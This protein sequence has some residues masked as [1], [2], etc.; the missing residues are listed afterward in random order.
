MVFSSLNFLFI[1]LPVFLILYY[2]TPDRLKNLTLLGGSLVFYA[3]GTKDKP[4]YLLL[5]MISIAAN[6]VIGEKIGT[7]GAGGRRRGWLLFGLIYNFGWLFLFKYLDFMLENINML[8]V[9]ARSEKILPL[10]N[11]VLPI[12][13]SFYTFQIVS[14]LFDVYRKEVR[15]E[16]SV[17][18]LGTYLCMFPQLI[19]GPIVS[20]ISVAAQLKRRKHSIR[21]IDEGLRIFTIGLGLKVL[22]ANQLGKL[23]NDVNTIGYESISTPLAW[24]GLIGFSL[25][26][27]FDFYGYSLMAIGLGKLLGFSL[28]ENFRQPYMALTMTDFWR[29]WHMTLGTWFRKYVYI[30]LGGSRGGAAA[31]IRNTLIVWLLTGIWHGASWNFILWGLILCTLILLERAG[32]GKVLN[33]VPLLGHLYMCFMI[34][35]TWL[36]FAITDLN[37]LKIYLIKLLPF[38]GNAKEAVFTEDYLKFGKIYAVTLLTGLLFCTGLP[39]KLYHKLRNNMLSVI[40]LLAVFWMSVYCMYIGM[41]DPFLYFRF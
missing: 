40:A 39:A 5:M 13:I 3:Y 8:S 34:P 23:W 6:F 32:L 26:I 31:A 18:S 36:F 21:K 33:K 12:G 19:A 38:L 27:Y 17:I 14:Y 1:F 11:L 7:K 15:P 41:D 4:I 22:L 37:Q 25:Q 24:L 30:P 20:Y 2:L 16:A 29:R 10:Q 28:P 35:F 9:L